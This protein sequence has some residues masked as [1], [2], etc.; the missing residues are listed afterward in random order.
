MSF[1]ILDSPQYIYFENFLSHLE[2]MMRKIKH[3]KIYSVKWGHRSMCKLGSYLENRLGGM[4]STKQTNSDSKLFKCVSI[5]S[6]KNSFSIMSLEL[7]IRGRQN[8]SRI[9]VPNI[10]ASLS[11]QGLSILLHILSIQNLQNKDLKVAFTGFILVF[12]HKQII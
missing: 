4:E 5:Y 11:S 1:L 6:H 8:R 10:G 9:H 3:K 7:F 12:T 2:T